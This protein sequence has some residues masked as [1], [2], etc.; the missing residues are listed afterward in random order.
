[1]REGSTGYMYIA[2][3]NEEQYH[4]VAYAPL[5]NAGFSLCTILEKESLLKV[6]D[7]LHQEVADSTQNM[8]Y[9]RILPFGVLVTFLSLFVGFAIL[10]KKFKPLKK[11][12]D[13]SKELS[14]GNFDVQA[15]TTSNDEIGQLASS[16][17]KMVFD[18]KQSR[19]QLIDLQI[20]LEKTVLERTDELQQ[21][22]DELEKYKKLTVD[23]E[24]KMIELKKE[25]N[26]LHENLGEKP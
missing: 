4:Y 22:I 11:L 7:D 15:D 13:A 23:R 3:G 26:K 5:E 25:I 17:N 12:T 21:K 16:F 8:V 20:S 6:I 9:G 1:M 14:K 2:I 10:N 24:L 18:L 19:K